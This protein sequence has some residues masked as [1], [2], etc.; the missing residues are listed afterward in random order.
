MRIAAVALVFALATAS[1]AQAQ[2][3]SQSGAR[4]MADMGIM[5][6]ETADWALCTGEREAP[7]A[8]AISACGRIIG[9]RFSLYHTAGAHYFRALLHRSQGEEAR[10]RR[11]LQR[12][13]EIATQLVRREPENLEHLHNRAA[14]LHELGDDAGL[15]Q[16]YQMFVAANPDNVEARIMLAQHRFNTGDYAGAMADFDAI[17]AAHPASAVVEAGRC[18][19][20][21]AANVEPDIARAACDEAVRLSEGSAEA[22]FSRGFLLFTQGE[23]EAA[24]DAFL[25]AGERDNTYALAAYGFA[26]TQL[27][28]GG[29]EARAQALREQAQAADP[30]TSYYA[31]AGLRP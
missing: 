8:R 5:R 15:L 3:A 22:H 13:L 25:A 7:P 12:A 14:V 29:D 21:A 24:V 27:R 6:Y 1:A 19:T 28:L 30:A 10:A 2:W 9:E 11:D 18:E 4:G 23:L 16:N 31:D 17:A 20:R 26:V